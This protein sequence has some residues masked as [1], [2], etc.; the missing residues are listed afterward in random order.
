M[1][2]PI[3][4]L[5]E[6]DDDTRPIFKSVLE[7]Q[8][9]LVVSAVSEAD[10][11]QKTGDNGSRLK[12]DLIIVDFVGKSVEE[13]HAAGRRIRNQSQSA[14][15]IVIVASVYGADLEGKDINI[16]GNDWVTY[17]EDGVQLFRLLK[18]LVTKG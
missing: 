17:L 16:S 7:G 5:I 4:F 11:L 3:A 8:G 6:E 14:S 9:F 13:M 18:N 15:P 10:A 1:T 2:Q 12:T